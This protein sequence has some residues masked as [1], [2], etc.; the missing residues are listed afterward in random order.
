MNRLRDL[1]LNERSEISQ[2]VVPL[3]SDIARLKEALSQKQA[4][5]AH[6]S[7]Q[8]DQIASAIKAVDEAAT[9]TSKPTIMQAVLEVLKDH[10][11][12]GM[13][14]QEILAEINTRYFAGRIPRSSLSPQLSRLKDRDE[15]IELRGNRWYPLPAEPTLFAPKK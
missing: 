8:L 10:E 5:L 2:K 14:A 1:L 3:V 7:S 15:K 9:R 4:E 11:V 12:E 13:T 6:W